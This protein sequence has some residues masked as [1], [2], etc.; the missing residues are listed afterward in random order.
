MFDGKEE[1]QGLVAHAR[2]TRDEGVAEVKQRV[3]I[4]PEE[5]WLGPLLG[6]YRE[7]SLGRLVV[8]RSADAVVVDAGEWSSRAGQHKKP[9][10]APELTL[11]DAPLAGLSFTPE[12]ENGRV[13]LV[14]PAGQLRYVFEKIGAPKGAP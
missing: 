9:G 12:T 10:G 2:K 13:T 6:E 1:A 4:P 11:L 14:L 8:R 5:A 3:A 7:A